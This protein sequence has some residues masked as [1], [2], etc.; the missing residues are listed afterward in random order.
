MNSRFGSS[1]N[2][3]A[4]SAT[5]AVIIT[6]IIVGS[7]F[8]GATSYLFMS[9]TNSTLQEV[10]ADVKAVAEAA[11]IPINNPEEMKK[12]MQERTLIEGAKQEGKLVYNSVA[13]QAV[14]DALKA[15]FERK[16]PFITV[17]RVNMANLPLTNRFIDESAKGK[18]ADVVNFGGAELNLILGK[19]ELLAKYIPK[20]SG[21]TTPE[22]LDKDGRWIKIAPSPTGIGF[23][24]KLVSKDEAPK[25]L[26][27]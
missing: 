5:V 19:G 3:S 26:L 10:R 23:N 11:G 25:A 15:S 7:V 12:L 9:R 8:G 17:E 24:T 27:T 16:Y 20:D 1:V 18:S 2:R 13:S 14:D 6:A 22:T 21:W 4:I